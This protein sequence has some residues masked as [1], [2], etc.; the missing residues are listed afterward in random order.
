MNFDKLLYLIGESNED[1]DWTYDIEYVAFNKAELKEFIQRFNLEYTPYLNWKVVKLEDSDGTEVWVSTLNDE[2][3]NYMGRDT[4]DVCDY[5]IN[6]DPLVKLEALGIQED[7][8][9]LT[10]WEGTI[11]N[12]KMRPGLAYHYTDEDSWEEIKEY[13]ELIPSR[14]SGL[15]N[16]G[17]YG[18][19]ATWSPETFED[20]TYGDICLELDLEG[21][22]N[23]NGFSELD[24]NPEPEVLEYAIDS[25]IL[26][27]LDIEYDRYSE[28]GATEDTVIIR[29]NIPLE[30]IRVLD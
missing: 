8:I 21:Y 14:G 28:D 5:I 27:I 12:L 25:S 20:G 29:H 11:K 10:G 1:E 3:Y 23:A 16:K 24:L 19:F 6:L 7:D 17:A 4:N 13:G 18:I 22:K 30:F 9:Y 26:N 15:Y 2:F